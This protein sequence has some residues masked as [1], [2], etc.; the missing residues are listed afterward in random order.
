MPKM[1]APMTTAIIYR[2]FITQEND[3]FNGGGWCLAVVGVRLSGL[4]MTLTDL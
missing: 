2:I 4:W 3:N 1:I